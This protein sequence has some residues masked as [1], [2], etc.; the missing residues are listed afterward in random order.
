MNKVLK[1]E[2][3]RKFGSQFLFSVH[4]G[5]HEAEVSRVIRGR[6]TLSPAKQKEWAELLEI[7]DPKRIFEPGCRE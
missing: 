4:A 5:I 3:V 1:A 2:I 7:P 6:Q